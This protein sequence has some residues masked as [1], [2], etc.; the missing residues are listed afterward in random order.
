MQD[1]TQVFFFAT[2]EIAQIKMDW[3]TNGMIAII[4]IKVFARDV[5]GLAFCMELSYQNYMI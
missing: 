2:A 3:I 4:P 1:L 5:S